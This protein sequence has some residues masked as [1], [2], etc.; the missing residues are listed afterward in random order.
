M[1]KYILLALILVS[2]TSYMMTQNSAASEVISQPLTLQ[3]GTDAMYVAD[4][5]PASTLTVS[6]VSPTRDCFVVVSTYE[7]DAIGKRLGVSELITTGPHYDVPINLSRNT[8]ENQT[9]VAHLYADNGDGV[10]NDND[11]LHYDASG[12]LV[13]SKIII[14]TSALLPEI[15]VEGEGAIEIPAETITDTPTDI[16]APTATET[17]AEEPVAET[18]ADDGAPTEPAP[19]TTTDVPV[20]PTPET[21]VDTTAPIETPAEPIAEEPVAAPIDPAPS[22][23]PT[24][25]TN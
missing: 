3:V 21:P 18:P 12:D 16:T 11:T 2:A 15:T 17:P 4:Q 22:E 5:S 7:N 20:E 19:E 8:Y 13:F 9:I 24:E 14:Q 23:T 25:P 1:N 6:F 10:F